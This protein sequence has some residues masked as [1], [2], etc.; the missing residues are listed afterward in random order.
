MKTENFTIENFEAHNGDLAIWDQVSETYSWLNRSLIPGDL[1]SAE[2]GNDYEM[3]SDLK[4]N[5]EKWFFDQFGSGITWD[6]LSEI[7]GI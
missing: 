5:A 6:E 7:F 3:K 2:P 1:F 4:E